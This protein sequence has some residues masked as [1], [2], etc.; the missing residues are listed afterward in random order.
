VAAPPPPRAPSKP[1][2]TPR[3]TRDLDALVAT[4]RDGDAP[5]RRRAAA[6][7]LGWP[8][9][10]PAWPRVLDAFLARR[11]EL[12]RDALGRLAATVTSWPE[13]DA[14]RAR[15]VALVPMLSPR[16]L[17]A[18][19]PAWLDAWEQGDPR[20]GEALGAVD[21]E[22]LLPHVAERARR[23]SYAA[24]R[25]LKPGSSTALR[26]LVDLVRAAAPREVSHLTG[27]A[28]EAAGAGASDDPVDPIAG[29]DVDRLVG[30]VT[31][32]GVEKGLAVRAVHAMTAHGDG[33]IA[34]LAR[35]VVDRRPE[36]RSAALRALRAV[37]S[38]ERTLEAAAEAL[39]ME[40]RRD[41]V[42]QLMSSLGHGRY[43]P[44][45]P[46][47]IERLTDGD[48]RIRKGAH[49]ALRAWGR[50]AVPALRHAARRAR[51]DRRPHYAAVIADLE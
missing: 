40:T 12:D 24:A 19:V 36:V 15:A 50:D 37:A 18:L 51:P 6:R 27:R 2:F 13:G 26:A 30:V 17:R 44:A 46:I 23:G 48:P 1:R 20:A 28:N 32:R 42:I 9:A 11:I 14:E 49:A 16:Q 22:H 7:I 45:L 10:A 41:V 5:E 47:L 8:D 25:L 4:L 29:K 43:P 21:P 39:T 3:S 34:P 33:A 38:R 31:A 35:L